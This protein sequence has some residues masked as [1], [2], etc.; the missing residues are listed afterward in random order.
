VIS[1][2]SAG[3]GTDEISLSIAISSRLLLYPVYILDTPMTEQEHAPDRRVA[4]DANSAS[5]YREGELLLVL[6]WRDSKNEARADNLG[7]DIGPEAAPDPA[8]VIRE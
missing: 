7:F 8:F 3:V 4:T 2:T 5:E 6:C 1:A